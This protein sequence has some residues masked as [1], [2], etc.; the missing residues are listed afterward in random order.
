[1]YYFITAEKV[2]HFDHDVSEMLTR[3]EKQ[4]DQGTKETENEQET[5]EEESDEEVCM[6]INT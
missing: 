2:L 3:N 6:C 5:E 1:M 4:D